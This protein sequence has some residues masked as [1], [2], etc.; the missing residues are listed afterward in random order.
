MAGSLSRLRVPGAVTCL[1]VRRT[2][3]AELTVRLRGWVFA[4]VVG[5]EDT[6]DEAPE[7]TDP[8]DVVTGAVV[9]AGAPD[10]ALGFYMPSTEW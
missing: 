1:R 4:A 3:V 6:E 7:G 10:V 8:G 9:D 2:R 5:R